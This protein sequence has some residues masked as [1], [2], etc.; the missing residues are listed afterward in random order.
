[1]GSYAI[2]RLTAHFMCGLLSDLV[3][4][5]FRKSMVIHDTECPY[6][7]QVPLNNTNQTKIMI[8]FVMGPL[9]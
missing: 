8:I 6:C 4:C 5:K 2:S 3:I 7:D 1:M 9:C